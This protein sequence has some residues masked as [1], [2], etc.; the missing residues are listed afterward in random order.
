MSRE[1][2]QVVRQRVR[3]A[4]PSRPSLEERCGDR[5]PALA[6]GTIR[7]GGRLWERLPLRSRLR[8]V[9]LRR[10]VRLAFE[11]FN[12]MELDAAALLYHPEV[13]LIVLPQLRTFGFPTV[14]RGR[15]ERIRFQTAWIAEWGEFRFEPAE[16]I[17]LGDRCLVIGRATGAGL[18]SGAPFDMEW[19][20]LFTL[21][22]GQVIREEPF[23][24]HAEA[25]EAAGLT[26]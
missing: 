5:F 8:Q 21:S 15:E 16:L 18:A 1:N 11:A 4:D 19:A 10:Y 3:L 20:D 2:V 9:V 22:A 25:R 26:A 6:E 7:V 17:D 13:E 24:D 12:R 23:F 14:V